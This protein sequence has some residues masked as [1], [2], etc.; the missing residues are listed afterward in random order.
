MQKINIYF[1][2]DYDETLDKKLISRYITVFFKV[3]YNIN[4]V[5]EVK[6]DDLGILKDEKDIIQKGIKTFKLMNDKLKLKSIHETWFIY[7]SQGSVMQYQ[8]ADLILV[9]QDI[10]KKIPIYNISKQKLD[11]PL[12]SKCDK[13]I[14]QFDLLRNNIEKCLKLKR[15]LTYT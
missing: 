4:Y 9:L 5:K 10:N 12:N 15:T 8:D 6:K 3:N 2:L 11:I 14:E 1:V 7:I 13:K